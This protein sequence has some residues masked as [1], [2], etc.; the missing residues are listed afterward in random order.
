ML[1]GTQNKET[2]K[3]SRQRKWIRS[4][5]MTGRTQTKSHLLARKGTECQ[6]PILN[7]GISLLS[8]LPHKVWSF[9]SAD[10][11]SQRNSCPPLPLWGTLQ[12]SGNGVKPPGEQLLSQ[13]LLKGWSSFP[14]AAGG[15]N[16]RM[17]INYKRIS[18]QTRTSWRLKRSIHAAADS[19]GPY[20]L[21]KHWGI[22]QKG[23]SVSVLFC[24][25]PL[26]SPWHIWYYN[27]ERVAR[28]RM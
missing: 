1:P 15:Q 11:N 24:T 7:Q 4:R 6:G 22:N 5:E 12:S 18:W 21:L 20:M 26:Q 25:K 28:L 2:H 13:S 19:G 3:Q 9:L 8:M 10:A 14:Q 27:L 16:W 17:L 23:C